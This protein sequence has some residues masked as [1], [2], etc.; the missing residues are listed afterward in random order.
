VVALDIV[1]ERVAVLQRKE[2]PIEDT[3]ITDFLTNKSLNFKVTVNKEEAYAGA[4]FVVITTPT[5][6]DPETNYFNTQSI[7]SVIRDVMAMNAK[8]VM[9]IKSTVPVG[10]TAMPHVWFRHQTNH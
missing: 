6:Y 2:S 7:E 5:Y 3:E 9:V 10:Y 4:D 1:P 8:A